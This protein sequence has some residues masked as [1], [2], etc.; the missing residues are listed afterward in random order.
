MMTKLTALLAMLI[1]F[2]GTS[3]YA[4]FGG[5]KIKLDVL[6]PSEINL[7]S[8]NRV[9]ILPIKFDQNDRIFNKI[10]S[11]VHAVG[12]GM[13]LIEREQLDR[14]LQEQNLGASELVDF[15][16][17]PDIGAIQGVDALIY[18]TATVF[19]IEDQ[20]YKTTV[21]W[22]ESYKDQEGKKKKREK[23]DEAQATK[24]EGQLNLTVKI[25]RV[26]TGAILGQKEFVATVSQ[27]HIDHEKSGKNK[28]LPSKQTIS[29]HLISTM[30]ADLSKYMFPFRVHR[31]IELD[32]KCGTDECKEAME[33]L[34]M[35]MYDM[36]DEILTDFLEVA[37]SRTKIRKK[38]KNKDE[39][40]A[41]ILYNLG[42]A[43]EA[44]ND[45]VA[46]KE[47][48]KEAIKVTLKKK[49]KNHKKGYD[50]VCNHIEQWEVYNKMGQ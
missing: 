48:Y 17:I 1:I 34:K 45:R 16:T 22:Q 10:A 18:G 3:T 25:V 40:L 46:A 30:M 50:R 4:F 32:K 37:R 42:V 14:I 39:G 28:A 23:K 27:T 7:S 19:S 49:N 9:A 31:E 33:M 44:Q 26:S 13:T 35:E 41:A 6:M 36:A 21:K 5:P 12:E 47:L 2:G 20:S 15:E 24:R 29:E 43:K 38:K 8:I 11:T